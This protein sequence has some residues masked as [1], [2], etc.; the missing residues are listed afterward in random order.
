MATGV[1]TPPGSPPGPLPDAPAGG[2]AVVLRAVGTGLVLLLLLAGAASVVVQFFT[3]ERTG[4]TTVTEPVTRL[5]ARTDTGTLRVRQAAAGEAVT[6]RQTVH[7]AFREPTTTVHAGNGLLTVTGSCE[8][9]F[10]LA[11]C[12]T[13]LEIVLPPGVPLDLTTDTG[14]IQASGSAAVSARTDTGDVTLTVPGAPTVDAR[15]GTGDV[16]VTGAAAG[17]SVRARTDTGSVS[18]TLAEPPSLARAVTDTGDITITVP[19]GDS[20][21]VDATTDTGGTRVTV[22][23]DESA[24]RTIDA[25]ADTGSIVVRAR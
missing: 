4:T 21:H 17:A 1:D 15:A 16:S 18:L 2:G 5:I 22:P 20:Y 6:V 7:W 8:N 9:R 14:D 23:R 24:P 11:R 19:A 13:D 25:R 12:D 10:W 3:Q